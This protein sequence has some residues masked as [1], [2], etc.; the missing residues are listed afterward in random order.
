MTQ[1]PSA[2][3]GRILVR[4]GR[5]VEPA[6]RTIREADVVIAD[7]RIVEIVDRA[8]SLA[9]N[10][11]A[12]RIV[13]AAGALVTPGL[14]DLHVHVFG[15]ASQLAVDADRVGVRQGV[16]TV[17][18]AGT[19]GAR[20]FAAFRR[21]VIEPAATR[22]LSWLNIATPGL[23]DGLSE[24][25]DLTRVG[26]DATHAVLD[27]HAH[28][29]IRGIKARMSRAVTRGTGL[30]ALRTAIEVAEAHALPIMVH[31][32]NEPP[33]LVEVAQLLR[34]GDVVS[35]AFHGKPGGIF[36]GG[37]A[38]HPAVL[39]A[40][41]RGVLFDVGH[42]SASLSFDTLARA[43][44]AGFAPQLAS[45]DLHARNLRGPVASQA[46][47]LSK[48]TAA[49]LDLVD[50]VS[51]ATSA[52]AAVIGEAGVLGTLAPGAPAELSIL[53]EIDGTHALTDSDGRTR[54]TDRVLR[55]MAAIAGTRIHEVSEAD[56]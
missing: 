50:V 32:G 48:L 6:D 43:L 25:A 10:D 35:H 12:D 2:P 22:V 49:G 13:D 27:A 8:S 17:V 5:V 30:A 7:G 11:A 20:D 51:M 44:D 31:V 34:T 53:R 19:T 39:D 56:L 1:S 9:R 41:A 42:G 46:L 40:R 18:D 16:T 54:T 37:D 28:S 52:A 15:A 24:L 29:E 14:I 33:S 47:T 4:G 26:G 45:T 21:D 23:V 36:A 3:G 55:P 38:I